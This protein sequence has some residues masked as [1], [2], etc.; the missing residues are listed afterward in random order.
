MLPAKRAFTFVELLVA[1]M[2]GSILVGT[3]VT[4][5]GLV[6][7]SLGEDQVRADA[8]QNAR[9]SLDRLSREV[10]QS[11]EVVTVLPSTLS[12]ASVTQP[13]E[14]Q[15]ED[16]HANDLT[17]KRY[18]L[19]GTTLQ[20]QVREYYFSGAPGTRVKWNAV[21]NGG[22]SPTMA[23][24]STQDVA[25]MVQELRFAGG[26]LIEMEVVTGEGVQTYRLRT[27]VERRN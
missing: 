7:R 27:S 18:Y 5:Y 25:E 13:G 19:S 2:V 1:V 3:S 23:V 14:I 22:V 26:S 16:G 15:F 4:L 10:R 21:G 24:I 12:D 17:Y 9:V 8:A 11:P 20:M 6:R